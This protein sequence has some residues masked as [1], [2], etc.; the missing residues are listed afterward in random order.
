MTIE[1]FEKLKVGDFV[2]YEKYQSWTVL[3]RIVE[4]SEYEKRITFY[5]DGNSEL[6]DYVVPTTLIIYN[7]QHREFSI[8]SSEKLSTDI[9]RSIISY[10]FGDKDGN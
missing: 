6:K 5:W 7:S 4:L 8:F 3:C 2:L 1:E 9:K 10:E